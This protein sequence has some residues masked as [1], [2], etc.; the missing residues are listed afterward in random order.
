MFLNLHLNLILI[1]LFWGYDLFHWHIV[2]ID[3][4]PLGNNVIKTWIT[5]IE[6]HFSYLDQNPLMIY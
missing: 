3:V 1:S 4:L 5:T 6:S 2:L